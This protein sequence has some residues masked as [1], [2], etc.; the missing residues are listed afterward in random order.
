MGAGSLKMS[1]EG[2]YEGRVVRALGITLSGVSA[3]SRVN[4]KD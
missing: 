2:Y 4:E 1:G 3:G